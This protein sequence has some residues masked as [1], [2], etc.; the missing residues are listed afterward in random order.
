MAK[1]SLGLAGLKLKS[2]NKTDNIVPMQISWDHR[3]YELK[4]KHR[5]HNKLGELTINPVQIN[6]QNVF[7]FVI[8]VYVQL[9][10]FRTRA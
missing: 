2:A 6:F 1:Q 7:K 5:G 9:A 3:V 8:V 10:I 4:S